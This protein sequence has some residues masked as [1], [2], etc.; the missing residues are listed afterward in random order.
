M[1]GAARRPRAV[2]RDAIVGGCFVRYAG[3]LTGVGDWRGCRG[4]GGML[5]SYYVNAYEHHGM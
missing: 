4:L 5:E 3:V 1:P 2:A